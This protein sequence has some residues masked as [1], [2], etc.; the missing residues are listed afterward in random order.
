[1]SIARVAPVMLAAL[2]GACSSGPTPPPPGAITRVFCGPSIEIAQALA[3]RYG[4][5]VVARGRMGD[6]I[7]M[8]LY[9]TNDRRTWTIVVTKRPGLS[10]LMAAGVSWET[11][12][13]G[14]PT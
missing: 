11:A 7:L 13:Q 8:Q 12:P 1:M 6:G 10:C 9:A 2:L 4:E 3:R 5:H 14:D